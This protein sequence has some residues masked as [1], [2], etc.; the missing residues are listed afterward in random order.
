MHPSQGRGL[1]IDTTDTQVLIAPVTAILR[2]AL[3]CNLDD[4]PGMGIVIDFQKENMPITS[5]DILMPVFPK[6][7]RKGQ[8]LQNLV[9]RGGHRKA[10]P[11]VACAS[12]VGFTLD[13]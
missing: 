2:K 13:H 6:V 12:F 10:R 4:D 1:I 3:L 8:D 9:L 11:T 5:I 7:P